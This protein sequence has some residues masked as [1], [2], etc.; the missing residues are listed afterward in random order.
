M[1]TVVIS[2]VNVVIS[3]DGGGHFWV[4]MQY[5]QGLHQLGCEVY[6]LERFHSSGDHTREASALSTFVKCMERYGLAGKLMLYVSQQQ[7]GDSGQPTY[8][9]MTRREAEAIVRPAG[10]P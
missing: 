5:V 1:L 9:G 10:R 6:W 4:F 2:P 7:S 3:P 8:L